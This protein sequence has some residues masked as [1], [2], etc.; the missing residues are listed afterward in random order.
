MQCHILTKSIIV[1]TLFGIV[2]AKAM[3]FFSVYQTDP[4]SQCLP[5]A[6]IEMALRVL[7]SYRELNM[8]GWV[9]A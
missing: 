3:M 5:S 1:H 6:F 4:F 9:G 2:T 7:G 8:F